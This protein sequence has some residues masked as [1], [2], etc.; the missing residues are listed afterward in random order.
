MTDVMLPTLEWLHTREP[1]LP[2]HQDLI[3]RTRLLLLDTLA[4]AA[5]GLSAPEVANLAASLAARLPGPV[6]LPGMRRGTGLLEGSYLLTMAACRDE[7]C[8]GLA[9]AHG[10]PGLHA[11]PVAAVLG[12]LM[13]STLGEVLISIVWG[14]EV[15]GRAGEAMRIHPGQHVDGSWGAVGSAATAARMLGLGQR[16]IQAAIAIAAGQP[17]VGILLPVQ[18]GRTSRNTY[19]A[20]GVQQGLWAAMAAEAGI[21]ASPGTFEASRG[22]VFRPDRQLPDEM[23]HPSR[24]YL[25]EGYLKPFA[26]VRHIHYPAACALDFRVRYG[27]PGPSEIEQIQ[28]LIY[29]E[30]LQYCGNRAPVTQ[31]QAQ[32]SLSWATAYALLKGRLGPEAFR[33]KALR[34]GEIRALEAR[35]ELADTGRF[36]TR[37]CELRVQTGPTRH[38][39]VVETIAGDPGMPLTRAEVEAKAREYMAATLTREQTDGAL[40]AVLDGPLHARFR[41]PWTDPG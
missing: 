9:R 31:I 20:I 2:D 5:A 35:I 40:A 3:E 21:T 39:V 8:E 13:G 17:S 1:G 14:Y 18:E 30:A 10:R 12:S 11:V 26:G 16:A 32:F 25:L 27:V 24:F 38:T 23:R 15:G 29:P 37:G 36:E 7:A 6:T 28:L 22:L 4:C 34:D 41:L 19:A 33:D